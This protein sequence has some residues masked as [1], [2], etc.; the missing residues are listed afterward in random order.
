MR[1]NVVRTEL[2]VLV[3]NVRRKTQIQIEMDVSP[4]PVLAPAPGRTPVSNAPLLPVDDSAIVYLRGTEVTVLFA[5]ATFGRPSAVELA[6]IGTDRLLKLQFNREAPH[7]FMM[8][9][10]IE[11]HEVWNRDQA[12]SVERTVYI[13]LPACVGSI[14]SVS[15]APEG[16]CGVTRGS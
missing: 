15:D 10:G 2:H 5:Q 1:V 8:A 3:R 11:K 6:I 7:S 16:P 14:L 4:T 13:P 9:Y 12:A